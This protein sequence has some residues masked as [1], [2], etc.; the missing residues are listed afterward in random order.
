MTRELVIRTL[1][2]LYCL[3][4]GIV[5]VRMGHTWWDNRISGRTKWWKGRTVAGNF[6]TGLCRSLVGVIMLICPFINTFVAV[7]CLKC[8][9][10]ERQDPWPR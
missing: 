2:V 3:S 6:R 9:L 8:W 7:T 10:E 1:A 5:L 4:F